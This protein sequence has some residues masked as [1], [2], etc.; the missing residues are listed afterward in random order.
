M[1]KSYILLFISFIFLSNCLA[2]NGDTTIIQTIDH[3]TPTLKWW[4][5][6]REGKYEFPSADKSWSKILMRYNLKCDPTQN[7]KC[8]EWDYLTQTYLREFTGKLDSNLYYQPSFTVNRA[9]QDTLDFNNAPA[10]TYIPYI[11]K[12]NSTAPE[13]SFIIGNSESLSSHPF[14]SASPNRKDAKSIFLY[15]ADELKA[16][17]LSEGNI[18]S[19][20]LY[21]NQGSPKAKHFRIRLANTDLSELNSNTFPDEAYTLVFDREISIN[22][23]GWI[24]LKFH[25]NFN[26][27]EGKNLLVEFTLDN[28]HSGNAKVRGETIENKALIADNDNKFLDFNIDYIEVPA[29]AFSSIEKEITVSFW[30][31]GDPEKTPKSSTAFRAFNSDNKRVF[32]AHIPW[33]NNMIYWDAGYDNGYDRIEMNSSAAVDRG[34]WTHWAFTKNAETGEMHIYING[35]VATSGTDKTKTFSDIS[36]FMIGC[37]GKGKSEFYDG[38]MDNFRIWNKCLDENTIA[39]HMANTI[40][41][42]H[43]F[44]NNL[45]LEFRFNEENGLIAEDSSPNM[46]NGQLVGYPQ[47]MNHNGINRYTASTHNIRPQIKIGVGT[48]DINNQTTTVK[49]DTIIQDVTMLVRYDNPTDAEIPTD[50]SYV[51]KSWYHQYQYDNN[52]VAIDSVVY[53]YDQRLIKVDLPYYGK[54]FEIVHEYE[55]GRF[56]TPYGIGLDLGEEGHTWWFDVTDFAPLLHDSV[57]IRSGNFQELLDLKFFMIE[58]TPPREVKNIQRLWNGTYN[59]NVFEEKVQ[60]LD[61]TLLPDAESHKV[62][63]ITTGHGFDKPNYCAEFCQ[64]THYLKVNGKQEFDWQIL[65]ECADNHL[66]PQGGTW[67]YDRAGWCPGKKGTLREFEITDLISDK[68][69]SLDYDCDFDEKGNYFVRS[70]LIEYGA[71]NYTY[72]AEITDIVSPSDVTMYSRFNPICGSPEIM[73]RNKGKEELTTLTI[74]YGVEGKELHEFLW[75]GNLRFMEETS[76]FLPHLEYSEYQEGKKFNVHISKPNGNDDEEQIN[77]HFSSSF[78]LVKDFPTT[79]NIKFKTNN[80]PKENYYEIYDV[81]GDL[82]LKKDNFEARK[83]YIEPITLEKGCYK[84]IMYDSGNDG[85]DFWAHKSAGKGYLY[86]KDNA[87]ATLHKFQPDFGKYISLNFTVGLT[88]INNIATNPN[89]LSLYPNPAQNSIYINAGK[90][91]NDHYKATIF[92]SKGQLKQTLDLGKGIITNKE[93]SIH[94]L[95]LGSYII[96]V[97]SQNNEV[98]RVKFIKK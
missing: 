98:S 52:A 11:E 18:S 56:I 24:D 74:K 21:S 81:N 64:K 57:V 92:D 40:E 88:D 6:P 7:P 66:Y 14:S 84:F 78:S 58:G 5:A 30:A 1:R 83:T 89:N 37:E 54:P 35:K 26:L 36:S 38:Y 62:R 8:G 67:V 48:I 85:I 50:T 20:Q 59:L 19:I 46:N 73:I 55:L 17:G 27:N 41:P 2:D 51:Y 77:D 75:K 69:I 28:I 44:Y 87:D 39:A 49:V 79:F 63:I 3:N 68:S 47:R 82:I 76:V 10:Y 70:Y 71:P 4:N 43:P 65:D 31:Y 23:T 86:F 45:I 80:K 12:A 97:R 60:K 25:K 90:N 42:S 93:I 34:K 16:A 72:N 94:N 53:P 96:E 15:T 61:L 91:K 22:D 9:V 13:T 95:P 33:S 32:S 29:K